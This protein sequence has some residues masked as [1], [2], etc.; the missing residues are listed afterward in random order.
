MENAHLVDNQSFFNCISL[1]KI[2]FKD[3]LKILG[4]KVFVGCNNLQEIILPKSLEKIGELFL[5]KKTNKIKI[6][7]EGFKTAYLNL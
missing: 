2:E 7:F 6:I 4:D 5:P 1:E 3:N